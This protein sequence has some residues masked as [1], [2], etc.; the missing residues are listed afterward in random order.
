MQNNHQPAAS[1]DWGTA[2][3]WSWQGYSCHWQRQGDPGSP[4][5]V[6][7]HGF[8]ASSGHWRRNAAGLAAAGWCVYGL[9]PDRLRGFEPAWP[10]PLPPS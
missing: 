5:L 1:P 7:L 9:G 8:G 3:Q 6:L 10:R 4:A 2:H